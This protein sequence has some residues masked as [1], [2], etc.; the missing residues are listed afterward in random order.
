MTAGFLDDA[1]LTPQAQTLFEEDVAEDG[2]V[3]NVSRLWAFQ[4]DTM[5][6]L[7]ELMSNAF[8]P[9]RLTYRQRAILVTALASTW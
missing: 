7:F 3:W 4:P 2:Y 9:S 8:R 5:K 6:S 1:P